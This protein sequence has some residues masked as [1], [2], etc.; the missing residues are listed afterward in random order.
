MN[1]L[2]EKKIQQVEQL[3][4][5]NNTLLSVYEDDN[6]IDAINYTK[7]KIAAYHMTVSILKGLSIGLERN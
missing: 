6:D 7:G 5:I 3:I 1:N 4:R 2:I